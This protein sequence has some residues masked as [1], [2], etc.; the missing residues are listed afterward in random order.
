MRSGR[1]PPSCSGTSAGRSCATLSSAPRGRAE[2]RAPNVLAS[3]MAA[4]RSRL[5]P[6]ALEIRGSSTT[7]YWLVTAAAPVDGPGAFED[8][9]SSVGWS[10]G[11][12]APARPRAAIPRP[13]RARERPVRQEPV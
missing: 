6:L 8:E 9:L 7:G 13:H 4:L 2:S 10:G 3:R 11:R 12:G 5:S 1:W